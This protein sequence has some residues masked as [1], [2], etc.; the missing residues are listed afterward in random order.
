MSLKVTT[1]EDCHARIAD[2]GKID[3]ELARIQANLDEAAAA[4]QKTFEKKA[5]PLQ[6]KREKLVAL[7]ER[8][9]VK[10]RQTLC[11]GKKKSAN[12]PTGKVGWQLGRAR[13]IVEDGKLDGLIKRFKRGALKRFVRTKESLNERAI[14]EDPTAVARIPEITIQKATETF[15]VKPTGL[16]LSGNSSSGC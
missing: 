14:L 3:A 16:E 6:A 12:L 2:I 4:A 5:A 9:C 11:P 13:I 8:Y 10:H 15:W 7:V 1:D